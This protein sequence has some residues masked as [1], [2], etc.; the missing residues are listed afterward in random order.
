MRFLIP[1]L[2]VLPL[3]M[4]AAATDVAAQAVPASL[5]GAWS[6]DTTRSDDARE[7]L[8]EA[9]DAQRRMASAPDTRGTTAGSAASRARGRTD[10]GPARAVAVAGGGP[11]PM[12]PPR[13]AQ[14]PLLDAASM[15]IEL[16][17]GTIVYQL[18]SQ[19]AIVLRPGRHTMTR[20]GMENLDVRTELNGNRLSIDTRGPNNMRIQERYELKNGEVEAQL[21]VTLPGSPETIRVK[22]I[23]TVAADG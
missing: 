1:V 2:S 3:A 4:L 7:K 16:L 20:W 19:N 9:M 8:M 13:G 10:T 17:D 12:G 22:R 21:S 11:R 23:Y 5:H 14:I 6:M 15:Q 18:G